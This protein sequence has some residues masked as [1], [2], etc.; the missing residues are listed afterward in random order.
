MKF[1]DKSNENCKNL[2]TET[3]KIC[4][5]ETKDLSK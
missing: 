3:Y 5:E 4:S 2:D 1:E